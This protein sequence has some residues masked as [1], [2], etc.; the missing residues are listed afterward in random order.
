MKKPIKSKMGFPLLLAFFF[1]FFSFFTIASVSGDEAVD[2]ADCSTP[3]NCGTK[4]NLS[5]P[6]WSLGSRPR[7]CGHPDFELLSCEDINQHPV[8]KSG[9]LLLRLIALNQSSKTLTVALTDFADTFCP[10]IV[11]AATLYT[12][13]LAPSPPN[14][15]ALQNLTLFYGCP[16]TVA[17]IPVTRLSCLIGGDLVS[18]YANETSAR[19]G[20]LG[21]DVESC[22]GRVVFPIPADVPDG[23]WGRDAEAELRGVLDAGVNVSYGYGEYGVLCEQCGASE[24]LCGTAAAWGP[25]N[26]SCHCLAGGS[27]PFSCPASKD[28]KASHRRQMTD[29]DEHMWVSNPNLS[30]SRIEVDEGGRGE[31]VERRI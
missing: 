11:G 2:F 9:S 30:L 16:P 12:S 8:L 3:F 4:T 5:Y 28:E 29:D 13:L 25:G 17:G 27:Q 22:R 6:F 24:G 18:F 15:A 23:I 20:D 14:S 7:E 19:G 21:R 26:F 1:F 31:S 10:P